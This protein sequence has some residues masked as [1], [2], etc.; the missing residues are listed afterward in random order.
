MEDI[1]K[2]T[3]ARLLPN[4]AV[5][6][7]LIVPRSKLPEDLRVE[8]EA[9]A[10]VKILVAGQ[11]GMGK[12]TELRRLEALIASSEMIPV[13][14]QFGAQE[15][16]TH[17]MLLRA[18]AR[19]LQ[20]RLPERLS[21]KVTSRFQA[22]FAHE[23]EV[24]ETEEGSGGSASVGGKAF[25]LK[26]EKGVHHKNTKK[27]TTKLVKPKNVDELVNLFNE[28]V[29]EGRKASEAK[30]AFIVDDIDKIQD[31]SSI[32]STFVDASQTI[33]AIDAPCIFTVPITYA[34]SSS[35]RPATLAYGGIYR[36]PAVEVLNED[37][38]ANTAGIDHMKDVLKAPNAILPDSG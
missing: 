14:V 16:I 10:S 27:T 13:F 32:E 37:G 33:T 31:T 11:R 26:A 7:E 19:A 1:Q 21:S 24:V 20:A 22:W 3:L 17:P 8:L 35:L 28:L 4:A 29:N 6:P 15:S 30:I 36:V 2:Q 23:E 18:M 25:V 5:G 12:S 34:T 38:T 9:S